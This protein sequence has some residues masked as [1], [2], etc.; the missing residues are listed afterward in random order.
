MAIPISANQTSQIKYNTR[1]PSKYF[2]NLQ[3]TQETYRS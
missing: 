1:M 2:S 3:K